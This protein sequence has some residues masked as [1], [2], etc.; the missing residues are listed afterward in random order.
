MTTKGPSR[1]KESNKIITF[2]KRGSIMPFPPPKITGDW[3]DI[4]KH[5]ETHFHTS[6]KELAKIKRKLNVSQVAFF[7][8]FFIL[9]ME[10]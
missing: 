1:L 7:R 8:K 4:A 10:D 6:E 5:L 3:A 2:Q 9:T